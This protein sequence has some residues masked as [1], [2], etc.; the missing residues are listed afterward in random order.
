MAQTTVES[1]MDWATGIFR[2]QATMPLEAG[3]SPDD[4]PR[5]IEALERDLKPLA[6]GEFSMLAWDNRGTL[7]NLMSRNPAARTHV[8]EL[9]LSL[10][11]EWSRISDDYKQIEAAYIID[12]SR[13][14]PLIFPNSSREEHPA[15]PPGWRAVP[16][17]DWTGIVIY[18]PEELP[19]RGTGLTAGV[20]PALRARILTDS[21]EVL[22]DSA[23]EG[24]GTLSYLSIDERIRAEELV[25]R[26]PFRTMAR[27]L[28]GDFPS[29]IILSE[30]DTSDILASESGRRALAEGRIIILLD[31]DPD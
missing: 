10:S 4:H 16:E 11:R 3:K 12:L 6:V 21:L 15:I 29:D 5:A 28:Y 7:E 8:E 23:I 18:V 24:S 2:I 30:D 19:V 26:R 25:G 13:E 20:I 22:T 14:I 9:A 31:G 27:G 1:S 17:D